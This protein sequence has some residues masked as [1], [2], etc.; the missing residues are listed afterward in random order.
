MRIHSLHQFRR[1]QQAVRLDYRALA[2]HPV[3]FQRIEPRALGRQATG[4]NPYALPLVLDLLIML[5]DPLPD[6]LT[7]IAWTSPQ[8]QTAAATSL[9]LQVA[10]R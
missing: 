10:H 9:L 5:A 8:Q 4:H 6:G 3:G 1:C 7:L 2:M